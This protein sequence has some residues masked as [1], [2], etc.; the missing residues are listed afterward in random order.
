MDC[1]LM[2]VSILQAPQL[3]PSRNRSYTFFLLNARMS[4]SQQ[5]ML[6]LGKELDMMESIPE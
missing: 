3:L 2:V 5:I 6:A 4:K 1:T